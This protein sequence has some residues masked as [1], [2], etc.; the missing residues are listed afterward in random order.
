MNRGLYTATTAMM[1]QRKRMDVV[2]N[3]LAN[4]ATAGFKEDTLLT[5]SFKD[6]LIERLND[7]AI[8]GCPSEVGLYNAGTHID[9]ISTSFASGVLEETGRNADLALEGNGFFAVE[10]PEGERY[11]RSGQFQVSAAGELVTQGGNRVLGANGP[12][13]VD[14]TAF[15]IAS[16]GTVQSAAGA[17]RIRLVSFADPGVLRKQGG[18]LY[19]AYGGEPAPDTATKV[20]QGYL[21]GSNVDLAGQMVDMIEITRSHELNQRIVRMMDEKLGKSANDIGRL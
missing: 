6:V 20:R 16:D 19:S 4:A 2:T 14:S 10:T 13:R 17:D 12:I 11:T 18:G 8:V 15:T 3:N 9:M 7:P 1:S 21:E 5:R